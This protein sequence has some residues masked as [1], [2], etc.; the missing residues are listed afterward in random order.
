MVRA[1]LVG[2][3]LVSIALLVLTIL[4]LLVG[5]G[6]IALGLLLLRHVRRAL[7]RVAMAHT[8]P[9][10]V[11]NG[12]RFWIEAIGLDGNPIP[13]I[14]LRTDDQEDHDTRWTRLNQSSDIGTFT[15]WDSHFPG[16]RGHF[17]RGVW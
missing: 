1:A 8:A 13:G 7:H 5:A 4:V 2:G 15:N 17:S 12:P 6:N 14:D 9:H 11:A 3:E 16:H 10:P